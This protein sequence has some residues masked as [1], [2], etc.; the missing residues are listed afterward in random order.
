MKLIKNIG[1]LIKLTTLGKT[2]MSVT[3]QNIKMAISPRRLL[4]EACSWLPRADKPSVLN[5]L[6]RSSSGICKHIDPL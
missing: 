4:H 6:L 1:I 2:H 3:S 5:L